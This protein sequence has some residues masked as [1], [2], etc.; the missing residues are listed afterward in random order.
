M[1]SFFVKV[2]R[3]CVCARQ[4]VRS[5]V[6]DCVRARAEKKESVKGEDGE[7]RETL[8]SEISRFFIQTPRKL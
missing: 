2:E 3:L 7:R 4:I 8:S 1:E 5:K 6:C